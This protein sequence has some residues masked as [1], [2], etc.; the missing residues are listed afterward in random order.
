M[1]CP[2][3]FTNAASRIEL[4]KEAR[5]RRYLKLPGCGRSKHVA[6]TLVALHETAVLSSGSDDQ[7][8]LSRELLAA[9]ADTMAVASQRR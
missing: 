8:R 5:F 7:I 9:S 2:V 6:N 4:Q 3:K 1:S